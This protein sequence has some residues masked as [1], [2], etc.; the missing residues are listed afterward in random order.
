MH[1]HSP[2][3]SVF[4]FYFIYLFLLKVCFKIYERV[5]GRMRQ[6][7][8][9]ELRY[10]PPQGLHYSIILLFIFSLFFFVI[11]LFIYFWLMKFKQMELTRRIH[12]WWMKPEP[13]SWLPTSDA[14]PTTKP[15]PPTGSTSSGSFKMV[16]LFL[17][18]Y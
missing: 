10:K 16:N 2:P 6:I 14:V 15:A 8:K 12:G 18:I 13:A 1:T 11:Y 17:L 7:D 3:P 5:G 9:S 4:I